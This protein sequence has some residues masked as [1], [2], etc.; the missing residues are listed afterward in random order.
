M[1][2]VNDIPASSI[3]WLMA[4]RRWHRSVDG[5]SECD[6]EFSDECRRAVELR[7]RG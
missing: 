5:G 1:G 2:G 4:H 6:P 7:R 3:E